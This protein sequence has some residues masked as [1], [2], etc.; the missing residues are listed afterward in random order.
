[1]SSARHRNVVVSSTWK[2]SP[3]SRGPVASHCGDCS[4]GRDPS[5]V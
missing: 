1:M 5:V 3:G 4:V 2:T